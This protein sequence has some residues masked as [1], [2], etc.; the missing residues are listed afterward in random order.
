MYIN[1]WKHKRDLSQDS[2]TSNNQEMKIYH[3]KYCEI[4]TH[5]IK[6]VKYMHYNKQ[7]LKVC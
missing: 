6:E 1:S 2:R 3:K 4:L 7:I 5:V